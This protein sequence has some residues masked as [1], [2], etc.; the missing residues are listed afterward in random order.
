MRS[1]LQTTISAISPRPN[2]KIDDYE[3]NGKNIIIIDCFTDDKKPYVSSGS[4][5]IR[6]G[7]NSQKLIT[8]DE[9]RDFFQ[10]ANKI[11]FGKNDSDNFSYPQDFDTKKFNHFITKVGISKQLPQK[12]ILE[13]LELFSKKGK[14]L[15]SGILF[16]A[17][18]VQKHHEHASVRCLLFKGINKTLI[19]DDKL[20]TGNLTE[21]YEG[22][23]EFLKSK[24]EL[25]YI[26]ETAG[27][28]VEKYEI[29]ETV[30]KEAIINALVHR[31]YYEI[32][33][34]THIEIYDNRVEITNPGGLVDTI[35]ENEFGQR[36]VS[37]NP[38]IFS[39]FQRL[40]LVEQVGS[41]IARMREK[42]K[43]ENL[44][45]PHFSLKGI[46]VVTLYRP[47]EFNKWIESWIDKISKN[48]MKILTE[49]NKNNNITQAQLS[50][51]IGISKSTIYNNINKLKNLGLLEHIGSDKTGYWTIFYKID[52]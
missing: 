22:A 52:M 42:M 11:F 8:A 30:F 35:K 50:D 6:I 18:N 13:N 28:R 29:P 25:R 15:N 27:P 44:P 33:G 31:D 19:F 48:Q 45:A 26:I 1:Q 46:F 4:I 51:L 23:L 9:I 47:I 38:K 37:R 32:G 24:L 49:I 21:Q 41:G 3:Y 39:F 43:D 17:K 5:Y 12:Q 2:L 20:I 14:F 7:A 34:K 40:D 36:S 16:F 10:Q